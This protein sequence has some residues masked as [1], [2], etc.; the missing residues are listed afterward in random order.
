MTCGRTVV[1]IAVSALTAAPVQAARL[2]LAMKGDE[3][4]IEASREGPGGATPGVY[5]V[6]TDGEVK[7]VIA[8]GRFP[9]WAPDHRGFAFLLNGQLSIADIAAGTTRP[10]HDVE[11]CGSPPAAFAETVP[12][13]HALAWTPDGRFVL[14]WRWSSTAG[15]RPYEADI[16]A[17]ALY[18]KSQGD[19]TPPPR[20]GGAE[21]VGRVSFSA[22]GSWA[23]YEVYDTIPGLGAS[24]VRVMLLERATSQTRELKLA[25]LDT[26]AV[27]NPVLSPTG[28]KVSVDCILSSERHGR[29]TFVVDAGSGR[30]TALPAMHPVAECNTTGTGWSPD[31][32]SLLV[33][34]RWASGALTSVCVVASPEKGEPVGA[35]QLS[36]MCPA[37]RW[38]CFSPDG[39]RVAVFGG[40]HFDLAEDT[41]PMVQIVDLRNLD[42]RSVPVT[43]ALPEGLRPVVIDW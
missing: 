29:R 10:C 28:G 35:R 23:A 21:W 37:V 30:Q 36:L 27:L 3:L 18:P 22:D 38:A 34:A 42:P 40:Q 24:A 11:C 1:W 5:A 32:Q 41:H 4:L 26:A 12:F 25:G 39:M 19:S 14:A 8:D 2:G 31:G 7:L 6:T 13:P 17:P 43:P 15:F 9:R 20:V 16:R 33:V